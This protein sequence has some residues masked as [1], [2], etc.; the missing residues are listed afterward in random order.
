VRR[1]RRHSTAE[2]FPDVDVV[3]SKWRPSDLG[4]QLPRSPTLVSLRSDDDRPPLHVG[5]KHVATCWA[6]NCALSSR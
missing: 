4:L 6:P 2:V 5:G 3:T 1:L